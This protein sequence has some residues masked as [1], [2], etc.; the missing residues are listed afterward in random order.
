MANAIGPSIAIDS[1]IASN[2]V[3]VLDGSGAAI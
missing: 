3:I 2:W 1:N